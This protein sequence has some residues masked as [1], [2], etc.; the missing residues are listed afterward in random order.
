MDT[1]KETRTTRATLR[2][3]GRL[4]LKI[5]IMV[6]AITGYLLAVPLARAH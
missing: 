6:A 1:G 5:G 4:S 2:M 3:D